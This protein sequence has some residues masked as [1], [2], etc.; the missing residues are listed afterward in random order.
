MARS[1][2]DAA[3]GLLA[4][5]VL[6]DG[7]V[8]GDAAKVFQWEDALAVLSPSGAPM[9][10]VTRPRGASKTTDLGGI[11]LAVLLE[12]AP[13]SA[14]LFALASDRDQGRHILAAIEGF[15]RRTEG[16]AGEVE[17]QAWRV[18]NRRNGAAL[19]VLA[20]DAASA[21]GLLP[22]F[23]VADELAQW[24]TT[25]EPRR[26]WEATVSAMAKVPGARLVVLTTAGDPTHWSYKVLEHARASR[27]WRVSEVSG[28]TPWADPEAL[29][30]QR[31]LLTESAYAR[32]HLNQWTAAEDR[33]TRPEDLAACVTLDGPLAASGG[34]RYVIGV[35]L[36]LKRDRTVAAVA[37]A[38]PMG[39]GGDTGT[40][41]VLDRMEVWAGSRQVP[42]RLGEVE[43][44]IDQAVR[45]YNNASVILDPWQAVGMAQRLRS[46]SVRVEEFTFSAGSVGRLASTLHLLLRSRALAL[47]DDDELLDELANVRLRE[48]SPGVLR[49]DHDADRHDDRAIA[50]ALAAQWLLDR[51]RPEAYVTDFVPIGIGRPWAEA[52][53]LPDTNWWEP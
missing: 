50:L 4:G 2:D 35:D 31:G 15:V 47:P 33:L 13:P 32:L 27:R 51:A 44:W 12:Q 5:L 17:V 48:T 30:E 16:L 20:A 52:A 22:Y 10:F 8:W 19:N 53:G 1:T 36:G 21:Y 3:L 18:L 45:T 26:V 7:R 24:K 14:Q 29:E 23:V 34:R 6:E 11:A 49:M 25:P 37:H 46:K 39:D 41:V 40:R 42:V 38:E 28:P 9:H 43:A